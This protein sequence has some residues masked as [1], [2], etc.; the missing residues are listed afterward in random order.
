VPRVTVNF[1]DVEDGFEVLEKGDYAV[2]IEKAEYRETPDPDKYD[3]INLQLRVT[4][5]GSE[6]RVL[7]NVLS[8]SPKALWRTKQT[9]ENLGLYEDELE[10]DYDEDTMDVTQPE[11]VG[12]PAVATVS[13]RMYEGRAQNQ[14]DV[15]RSPDGPSTKKTAPSGT[16]KTAPAKKTTTAKKTG[17]KLQ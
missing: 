12:L 8:L 7:F 17:R 10:I 4:E 11:L 6:N 13:Q 5:P 14:V 9:L 16:R 15:L 2:L 1:A 3:Y